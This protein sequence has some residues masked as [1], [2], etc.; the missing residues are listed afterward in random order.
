[1]Q[2]PW[3]GGQ[4]YKYHLKPSAFLKDSCRLLKAQGTLRIEEGEGQQGKLH[5]GV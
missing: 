3:P 1:M 2:W 5:L 4:G